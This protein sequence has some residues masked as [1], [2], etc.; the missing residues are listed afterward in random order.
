METQIKPKFYNNKKLTNGSHLHELRPRGSPHPKDMTEEDKNKP[1]EYIEIYGDAINYSL[2]RRLNITVD[3]FLN[4]SN[5]EKFRLMLASRWKNLIFRKVFM[6]KTPKEKPF[7]I[8]YQ[9]F[10]DKGRYYEKIGNP[11]KNEIDFNEVGKS[12]QLCYSFYDGFTNKRALYDNDKLN[13]N[14]IYFANNSKHSKYNSLDF[15]SF[16]NNA[17]F[18]KGITFT[19]NYSLPM[20]E[21]IVCGIVRQNEKGFYYK[22]WFISSPEFL[23]LWLLA[24]KGPKPWVKKE[25]I[26]TPMDCSHYFNFTHY[27]DNL[28]NEEKRSKLI[29]HNFEYAV[30]YHEY[31]G[32]AS[33]IVGG[34]I[35]MQKNIRN[36][37]C[38]IDYDDKDNHHSQ[39]YV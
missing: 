25:D 12:C 35:G 7:S 27:N 17:W 29:F 5:N 38:P 32:I 23:N 6:V 11:D 39:Y 28:T 15:G 2:D 10:D 33:Y 26:P 21:Q 14:S 16:S 30:G 8:R 3:K 19:S 34:E 13:N 20:K 37:I 31:E 22:K 36:N 18:G 24:R 9:G 1:I 4:S